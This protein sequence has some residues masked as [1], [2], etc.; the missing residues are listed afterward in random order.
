VEQ[1][2]YDYYRGQPVLPTFGRL[3]TP[4]DL[5]RHELDRRRL[6]LD[7]LSIP[8]RA[9]A[10][11][12]VLEFGPDAGGNA[13][14]FALWGAE[15]TLSEPHEGA[16]PVIRDYFRRFGLESS[17]RDLT[18]WPV[19]SYPDPATDAERF[20]VVDAEGFIHTVRPISRW[21][22]RLAGLLRP[23]GLAILF[24]YETFGSLLELVWRVV[25]SRYREL[26]GA[27]ANDA[28]HRLF[29]TK[30]ATIPHKRSIESWTMDVLDSPFVRL[31]M[32]LDARALCSSMSESGFRLYSS[33]PHYRDALDVRWFKR[34]LPV[35][36]ELAANDEF[37]ARS[38][39]S[40]VFG[41]PLFLAHLD[42]DLDDALHALFA[43]VD[44][45]I[46]GVDAAA[47]ARIERQLTELERLAA[48][49]AVIATPAAVAHAKATVAMLRAVLALLDR[50]DDLATFCNT[51]L[52]FIDAWGTPAHFA[53]FRREAAG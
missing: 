30:W 51:D 37:I 20:D 32:F 15:C 49:D 11:A 17:L 3:E 34:D 43:D 5:A 41:R 23:D 13:L 21:T 22:G 47:V 28:A 40:Y 6:F 39:L 4:A 24:Y 25:Q 35:A 42:P 14:V 16:H 48:S 36:E 45:L 12:R 2:L 53:V 33:W 27:D 18:S 52:T 26:T 1:N 46:D 29:A 8:P 9:L 19:E 44:G 50:P 31:P 38:R 10:G 7:R